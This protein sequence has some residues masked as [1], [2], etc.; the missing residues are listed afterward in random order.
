[1]SPKIV[2][3]YL[4]FHPTSSS[5]RPTSIDNQKIAKTSEKQK[6]FCFPKCIIKIYNS[7][8]YERNSFV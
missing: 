3:L 8:S 5:Y 4:S 6:G 1:M 2:L 7:F